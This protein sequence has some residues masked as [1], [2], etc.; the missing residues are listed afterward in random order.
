MVIEQYTVTTPRYNFPQPSIDASLPQRFVELSIH[1]LRQV[2]KQ[3]FQMNPQHIQQVSRCSNYS[4][5]L[6]LKRTPLALIPK[7]HETLIAAVDTSTIKIGETSTGII[8]AVRGANVWKQNK[9]YHYRR[10]GPFIF[11]ITEDNKKEVYNILERTYFETQ[12]SPGH[13]SAP[14]Y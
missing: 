4:M 10:L 8:I 6:Q 7:S 14:R 12:N 13:Q 11:H 2:R 9:M 3:T 5:S 1:S